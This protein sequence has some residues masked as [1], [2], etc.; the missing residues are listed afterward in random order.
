MKD[1]PKL[2]ADHKKL[3]ELEASKAAQFIPLTV[4]QIEAY[5]LAHEAALGFNENLG[6]KFSTYLTNHLKKLQ[7]IS[8]QYGS[9]ARVPENKQFKIQK[10][11]KA[12]EHLESELG[13][14]PSTSEISDFTGMN[15]PTLNSLLKLRKKEV[16]MNNLAHTPV[17]VESS[18]SDDWIHYV[19]HDLPEHDKVIFEHKTG[20]GNKPILANK[21]IAKK[22]GLTESSIANRVKIMSKKLN[23]QD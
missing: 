13:R 22:L 18:D 19:Y 10:I 6:I 12:M 16:N 5:K 9:L 21:D 23:K 11:N 20:F 2:L 1:I 14:P 7:R 17:F 3:I 8:T 4:A 15:M